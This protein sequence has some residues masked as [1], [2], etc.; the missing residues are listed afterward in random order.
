MEKRNYTALKKLIDAWEEYENEAENSNLHDFAGWLLYHNKKNR[1]IRPLKKNTRFEP[2][3]PEYGKY[4]QHISRKSRFLELVMR[5]S[6]FHDF[7]FRKFLNDLPINTRL[8]FLFLFSVDTLGQVRKTDVI[9]LQLVEFTTGMD[10][11]KRLINQGLIEE[12]ANPSDKRTRLL[13]ITHEGKTL[14]KRAVQKIT[15]ETDM[16]LSCIDENKWKKAMPV[17]EELHDFHHDVYLR[18][19]DKNDAELKNLIASLRYYYV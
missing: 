7:Y 2:L 3:F 4:M 10:I 1:N 15:E 5:I 17:L 19:N 12:F 9:H 16:L 13:D 14:L 18:Y 6:R 11:I 8:E